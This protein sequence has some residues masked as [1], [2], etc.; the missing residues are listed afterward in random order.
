MAPPAAKEVARWT[1]PTPQVMANRFKKA[2]SDS[3]LA[4]RVE[5]I[6]ARLSAPTDKVPAT[7]MLA[8]LRARVRAKLPAS[9]VSAAGA[10]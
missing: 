3:C 2:T 10:D 1:A 9:E 4:R 7:E 6:G 5:D 8:A